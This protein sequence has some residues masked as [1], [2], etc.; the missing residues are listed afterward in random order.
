[1]KKS[2]FIMALG[3]IALM[4]CSQDEIIEVKQDA[5]AFSAFTENASRA[6]ATTDAGTLTEFNVYAYVNED[7]EKLYFNEVAS[8]SDGIFKTTNTYYWPSAAVDFYC[9]YPSDK[10][11]TNKGISS[12]K[13][14]NFS[15]AYHNEDLLYSVSLDNTRTSGN[16]NSNGTA[17]INFRH[18]LAM[19]EFKF[20]KSSVYG[21]DLT[22]N[23]LTIKNIINQRSYEL[24]NKSTDPNFETAT[25]EKELAAA[26]EL[27]EDTRGTWSNMDG[28]SAADY[29]F[30]FTTG[31]L[32][33]G[34]D[35]DA[36]DVAVGNNI[37][38]FVMPQTLTAAEVV[39]TTWSNNYILIDCKIVKNNVTIKNGNVAIPISGEWKEGYKYTYTFKF[40]EGAGYEP[41]T[42]KPVVVPITWDITVDAMQ[43][44][45][46]VDVPMV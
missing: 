16:V 11:L 43:N 24:P 18:A 6:D 14:A 32:A 36:K 12:Y 23:S 29:F 45:D 33:V 10:T 28:V 37:S 30:S 8:K 22:I 20:E 40:G 9:V 26:D 38:Y 17:T 4:S 2:L 35:I 19:V 46:A 7:G 44:T 5:I 27:P 3:A 1:M 31:T 13:C 39:N 41:G 42:D 15:P 25:K 21:L 34:L